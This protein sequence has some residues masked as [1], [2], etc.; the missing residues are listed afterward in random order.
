[1]DR[2]GSGDQYLTESDGGDKTF[3]DTGTLV[4]TGREDEE[5]KGETP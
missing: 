3:S 4:G 5:A 2:P 1:M